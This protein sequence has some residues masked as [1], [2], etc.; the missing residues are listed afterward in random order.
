MTIIITNAKGEKVDAFFRPSG[1]DDET[2]ILD[3]NSLLAKAYTLKR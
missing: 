1:T 3:E 2:L